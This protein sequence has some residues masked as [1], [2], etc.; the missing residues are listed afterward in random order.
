MKPDIASPPA[1]W[2]VAGNVSHS[3][4][5]NVSYRKTEL[6]QTGILKNISNYQ[7]LEKMDHQNELCSKGIT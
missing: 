2:S 1:S 5:R 4:K 6:H 3:E 7:L